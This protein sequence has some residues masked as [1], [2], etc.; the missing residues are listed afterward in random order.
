LQ[1]LFQDTE[2]L[3]GIFIATVGF[4]CLLNIHKNIIEINIQSIN[5][6]DKDILVVKGQN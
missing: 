6:K 5:E 4:S 2:H 3:L 1:T